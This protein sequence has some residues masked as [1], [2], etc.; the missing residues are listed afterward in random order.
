MIEMCIN[1]HTKRVR[2]NNCYCAECRKLIDGAIQLALE[3]EEGIL[4]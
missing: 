1:C 2:N 4:S 3:K